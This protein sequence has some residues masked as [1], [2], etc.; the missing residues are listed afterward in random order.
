MD[1]AALLLI[2]P[3]GALGTSS[4]IARTLEPLAAGGRHPVAVLMEAGGWAD[5]DVLGEALAGVAPKLGAIGLR[6]CRRKAGLRMA[7]Q[8]PPA[9]PTAAG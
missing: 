5:E 1:T 2:G 3:A 6:V 9:P 7:K 8:K 4:R